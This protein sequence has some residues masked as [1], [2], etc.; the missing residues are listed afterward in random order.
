[1]VLFSPTLIMK[2]LEAKRK[3]ILPQVI[4]NKRHNWEQMPGLP[5]SFKSTCFFLPLKQTPLHCLSLQLPETLSLSEP[6][7][8][9]SHQDQAPSAS[10]PPST[11]CQALY[12]H[13]AFGACLIY[14]YMQEQ[15]QECC[16]VSSTRIRN[17]DEQGTKINL[18]EIR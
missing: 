18:Q 10:Y 5:G 16:D 4:V 1:M 15:W 3:S 6:S 7:S 12:L 17:K 11:T 2:K 8:I 13:H 9:S 14:I